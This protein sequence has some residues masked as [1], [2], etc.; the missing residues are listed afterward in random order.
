MPASLVYD[1][2]RFSDASVELVGGKAFHL[3]QLAGRGFPVPAFYVLSGEA[4]EQTVGQVDQNV[5]Q[6]ETQQIAEAIRQRIEAAT[7]APPLVDAIE[8]VHQACFSNEAFVAV[9]SSA[10]AEDGSSLSFAGM[11]ESILG[12]RGRD[13]LLSAIKRVWMSA[14]S[15]RVMAYRQH[16]GLP[17]LDS[18]MAVIVQQM[19]DAEC[20]GVCFTC[21]PM[22]GSR[23]RVFISSLWGLG[24]GLVS[25]GF[26]ADSYDVDRDSFAIEADVAEKSERLAIDHH[27]GRLSRVAV[28]PGDRKLDSLSRE[29]IVDVTKAAI[30]IES[31]FGEPQDVEFCFSKDGS[32]SIL[33]SRPV[34]GRRVPVAIDRQQ[35]F[36]ENHIVW[37]N[38]N[39]I[40][41]Y[42]GV[43]TPMTFSFVR[44]AYSIVYH[45]FAEVMGISPRVVQQNQ[46]TFE[47]MLG[48]FHGRVYYNLKNWYRLVRMFP[49]Y[50]Y[51]RNF[52]ES[53]MGVKASLSLEEPP[54]PISIWRRWLVEF[55][56]LLKLL[57]RSGWNFLRIRTIVSQFEQHFYHHHDQWVQIDFDKIAPHELARMYEQMERKMLW[58]WKAPIINDFYVMVFYGVLRKMCVRWCDDEN[59]S[60]QNGLLCGEG[61]LRSDEPAK[62]LIRMTQLVR[63]DKTLEDLIRHQ[64]IESLPELIASDH[65]FGEFNK[66]VTRYLDE[67][68]LRC[69]NELKLESYSYREQPHRLYQL[70]REY[71][72]AEDDSRLDVGAIER[73]EQELRKSAE[74]QVRERLANSGGWLP[75]RWLFGWVLKNARLGVRNR[76]NMRFARTRIYGILR[77]MLRSV[78]QQFADR[79]ILDDREDVFYLT[80]DE[81]WSYV[82]GTAVTTDLRGLA[83]LRRSAYDAYRKENVPPADRF[84]TYDLPYHGNS[85]AAVETNRSNDHALSGIGCCPGVV[86]GT[87]QLVDDPA[88]ESGFDGDILA[89]ERT[90]PGWVPLFPAFS[91]ILI[92]RGSVLSHSA[93][94][95]RE[96]GIPT[97]V[98]IRGLT[99]QIQSG[100]RVVM[101]GH[102]G[103]V[104]IDSDP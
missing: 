25:L 96:M 6:H 40:E 46:D 102:N 57:A 28:S 36:P 61:G 66:L 77:R 41:S 42:S 97:I 82:K 35:A 4:I 55:P 17:P 80:L 100:Q 76:E 60:L 54:A 92:E 29:Q 84:E 23:Q 34:T 3:M 19:V 47:N 59:A 14:L 62:L 71:L 103:R 27:S 87:V 70:I 50:D 32:L 21:E 69:A 98:G 30:E 24:E 56:A 49:G 83:N 53:M 16:H 39:I 78:G 94:V 43:T 91:G 33:Q 7:I 20:S 81:V 63:K 38:S 2:S 10:I 44:R 45:C 75:R 15:P 95:A 73:R 9:R 89:A 85:I 11:Y 1:E 88:C 72:I 18:R 67:F 101:D 22:T 86:R 79:G 93:I 65:H 64:S 99:Q 8:S 12:V 51:N 26:P 68:G 37:D 5:S 13:D 104:E 52:M 90:D 58:N 48:L 74:R 31:M